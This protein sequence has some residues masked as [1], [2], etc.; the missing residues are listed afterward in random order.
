[1]ELTE[2][3]LRK[4]REANGDA[5]MLTDPETQQE[6]VLIRA[7]VHERLKALI[8]DD[9]PPTDEEKRQ[10]LAQ[11]GRRAGWDDPEMDIYDNYD[12]NLKKLRP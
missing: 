12:E 10:Q 11:S 1:M 4:V 9:S 6:Y 8:Y 5:I 2:E 3:Q 7:D